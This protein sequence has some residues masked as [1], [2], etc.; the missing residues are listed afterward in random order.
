MTSACA[1]LRATTW[2]ML[3]L[4]AHTYR[5]AKSLRLLFVQGCV[6]RRDK[7]AHRLADIG[8]RRARQRYRTS[9]LPA[10]WQ[11]LFA[12][13]KWQKPTAQ[14]QGL[15]QTVVPLKLY[16][17]Y[18]AATMWPLPFRKR[19]ARSIVRAPEAHCIRTIGLARVH[20]LPVFV[21][22]RRIVKHRFVLVPRSCPREIVR[23]LAVPHEHVAR[24]VGNAIGIGCTRK[25]TWWR[26][27]PCDILHITGGVERRCEPRASASN[28]AVF[29]LL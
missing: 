24:R 16:C 5:Q 11:E 18:L 22:K 7:H 27:I 12:R 1:P 23:S 17:Q 25:T 2:A 29:P 14:R 19:E 9:R 21:N 15:N 20:T 3:V 10:P 28:L 13:A 6:E 8:S 4:R 26:Y